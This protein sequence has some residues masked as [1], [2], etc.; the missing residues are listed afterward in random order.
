MLISG[1]EG[2]SSAVVVDILNHEDLDQLRNASSYH[3]SSKLYFII[4]YVGEFDKVHYPLPLN[5]QT[6]LDSSSLQKT[7]S[8]LRKEVDILKTSMEPHQMEISKTLKE[9][10]FLKAQIEE[11]R[12]E[13]ENLGN[14]NKEKEEII[15]ELEKAKAESL[16]E[17][18]IL[19]K[20]N[21]GMVNELDKIRGHMDMIIEQLEEA[22]R[23]KNKWG[24]TKSLLQEID[25]QKK[26]IERLNEEI[27]I[28]K[29]EI[30]ELKLVSKKDKSRILQ[31]E[32]E[33]R[34]LFDRYRCEPLPKPMKRS[35]SVKPE[36]M[37]K[38][39]DSFSKLR[40]SEDSRKS[41]Q[42]SI[43]P[44][45]SEKHIHNTSYDSDEIQRR[46][47]KIQNMMKIVKE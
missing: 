5:S 4:T 7:I 35:T 30:K 33:L 21:D 39:T 44:N 1:L 3:S 19:Q 16:K 17:N 27:E 26:L 34:A 25:D 14:E 2:T 23:E 45:K 20:E 31:L 46:L 43:S 38:S 11:L 41:F 8:R 9:N 40:N 12:T 6:V 47:T 32:S 36:S 42:S 10:S 37:R 18:K 13:L 29:S 22:E 28:N 24:S 15:R